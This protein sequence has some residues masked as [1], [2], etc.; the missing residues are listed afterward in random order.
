VL[1]ERTRYETSLS[2]IRCLHDPMARQFCT[3]GSDLGPDSSPYGLQADRDYIDDLDWRSA[4]SH[5]V[6]GG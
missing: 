6:H 2:V 1:P 3:N 5:R 4:A